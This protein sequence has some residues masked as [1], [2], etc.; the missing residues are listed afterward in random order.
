MRIHVKFPRA[1]RGS[2]L[3]EF[4]FTFS[5][6]WIPIF[7]G[8][9]VMGFGLI[10]AVQVTQVCRD[11]AHM[12]SK[13]VDFTQTKPQQLLASLAAGLNFD[14]TGSAGNTV[15]IFST[16]TYVDTA[17]CQAG[18]YS[19]TCPNY[20]KTVFTRRIAV[21]RSSLHTSTYGTPK[22][23]LM[24]STGLIGSGNNSGQK[25]YLNDPTAVTTGFPT[26]LSSGQQYAY[27][28]ETYFLSSD[29][30]WWSFLGSPK[31]SATSIF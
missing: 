31:V 19:S 20:Q 3:I 18:G 22:A 5:L 2:A 28:A 26:L 27:I 13:G 25:G 15:I 14:I 1:D 30:N 29:P 12:Y 24:D 8:T 7:F 4:V 10:R 11:A 17:Q 21:G 6:F 23:T 9:L 16:V